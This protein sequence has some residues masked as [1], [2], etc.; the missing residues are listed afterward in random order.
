M[1]QKLIAYSVDFIKVVGSLVIGFTALFYAAG[2]LVWNSRTVYLGMPKFEIVNVDFLIMGALFF[3][4][5]PLRLTG[6]SFSQVSKWDWTLWALLFLIVLILWLRYRKSRV[7]LNKWVFLVMGTLLL[8]L[9]L[10]SLLEFFK[11]LPDP[12]E[13]GVLFS[14]DKPREEELATNYSELII[15]TV[16]ALIGTGLTGGWQEKIKGALMSPETEQNPLS[17]FHHILAGMVDMLRGMYRA[18]SK[19]LPFLIAILTL[20][21][22]LMLP[23]NFIHPVVNQRYPV[24]QISFN[25]KEIYPEIQ[26]TS[27]LFLLKQTQG[28][29]LLYSR[30]KLKMWQIKQEYIEELQIIKNQTIW[31]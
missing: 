25:Q 9:L 20:I 2:F 16:L 4:S 21:Y 10:I 14:K 19:F 31:E 6:L 18:I 29:L 12:S 22:L 27:E 23:I 24:I 11:Y 1:L 7:S 15:F 3:V 13:L 26:P 8:I 5:L 28:N 17:G 30:E